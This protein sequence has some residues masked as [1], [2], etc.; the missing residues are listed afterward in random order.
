MTQEN[1]ES[2]PLWHRVCGRNEIMEIA[3]DLIEVFKPMFV[4]SDGSSV[5]YVS[6]QTTDFLVEQF[7]N[8]YTYHVKA[9]YLTDQ[10]SFKV[11]FVVREFERIE[12]MANEVKT[13]KALANR[14]KKQKDIQTAEIIGVYEHLRAL[15]YE[16]PV[17]EK[18]TEIDVSQSLV[19]FA[20]GRVCASIHGKDERRT[21]IEKTNLLLNHL[22]DAYPFTD[23]EKVAIQKLSQREE[24][25][26]RK[27]KGGYVA[28]ACYDPEYIRM[29]SILPGDQ[30]TSDLILLG[31]GILSYV[32]YK[33]AELI[34]QDRL[35]EI[36]LAFID[37]AFEEF[38]KQ[39]YS[40]ETIASL[41]C[42]MKGYEKTLAQIGGSPLK[43][44]Y[45]GVPPIS[46][47]LAIAALMYNLSFFQD[48]VMSDHEKRLIAE[49]FCDSSITVW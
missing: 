39:G 40:R 5:R 2:S 31:E 42:F 16:V 28:L 19:N 47:Y 8:T 10:G 41:I 23:E 43:K 12:H 24:N 37:Q 13:Y 29:Q 49:M 32:L 30:L 20:L 6:V 35:F 22:L 33:P 4:G 27:S 45:N 26:L 21:P 25:K 46:Y 48:Q 3:E 36:A 38:T 44:L 1:V 11:D 34:I 9:I 18:P 15:A 14:L 17:G 7:K